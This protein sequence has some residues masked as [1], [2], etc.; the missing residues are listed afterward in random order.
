MARIRT[1]KPEFWG[2]PD[3]AALSVYTRLIFIG[4]WN[5]AEDNGVGLANERWVT[6]QLFPLDD[7]TPA[8]ENVRRAFGELSRGGQIALFEANGRRLYK[9][10]GWHHQKIDKPNRNPR[11]KLPEEYGEGA[12]TCG[13]TPFADESAN[14]PRTLSE[15]SGPRARVKDQGEDQVKEPT[16]SEL[17]LVPRADPAPPVSKS[18]AQRAQ[19]LADGYY[20]LE[21]MCNFIGVK[22][23]VMTALEQERWSDAQIEEGLRQIA[24]DKGVVSKNSL[25]LA[26]DGSPRWRGNKRDTD[27][28]I[29]DA[30]RLFVDESCRGAS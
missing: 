19:D 20:K 7:P 24:E 30:E 11:Y 23:I 27:A 18:I 25:R 29:L 5:L 1:V 15:P 2:S 13:D 6:S 3:V 17:A 21:K 9:I 16:P 10:N 4:L 22:K 8:V 28:M 26:I 14:V 12:V